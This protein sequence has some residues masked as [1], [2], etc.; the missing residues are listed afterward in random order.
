MTNQ[1]FQIKLID[2][3]KRQLALYEER[4]SLIQEFV[5]DKPMDLA[6]ASLL[7]NT[8]SVV[9]AV[10]YLKNKY[11]MGISEAKR[12]VDRMFEEIREYR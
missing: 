1:E 5:S 9:Q 12:F 8:E 6:V 10:I 3:R 2:I 4:N 11:S 7:E